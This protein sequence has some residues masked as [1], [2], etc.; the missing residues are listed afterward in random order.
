MLDDKLINGIRDICSLYSNREKV[1]L[2]GS[3]AVNK[4]KYNSDID[5]ALIGEFDILFCERLK[6]ELSNLPTLLKFDV[7]SYNDIEN[8]E[9]KDSID[10][11][12]KI[13]YIKQN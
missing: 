7:I 2:F 6:L 4:E 9:L 8:K 3:R 11:Y 10:T 13:I 1:I 5:L 12:G